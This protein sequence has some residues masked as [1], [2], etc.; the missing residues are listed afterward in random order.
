MRTVPTGRR[1]ERET[2]A[3]HRNR[4]E[5]RTV[6]TNT[7]NTATAD[8]ER[9]TGPRAD[10]GG[11]RTFFAGETEARPGLMTTE[12]WL[13]ILSA[14]TLVIA[15]YVSE[16]FPVRLAWALFAGVIASYVISRGLAKSGSREGPFILGDRGPAQGRS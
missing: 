5:E 7:T 14:A 9:G 8:A 4:Q 13:T 10:A 12:H 6:T 1:R 16:A 2:C 11:R 15:G 3:R